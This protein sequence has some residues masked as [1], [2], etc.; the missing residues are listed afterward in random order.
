MDSI[1]NFLEAVV[2]LIFV[3][4]ALGFCI[5]SHELGHFLAAKWRGLHIDAFSLGFKPFWRKKINGVEYRLGWL[6]FG[7]YVELPQVDASD[8]VPKAADGTELPR[9]KPLDRIITAVAGPLFNILSGLLLGCIIWAVGMPQDSPRMHELSVLTVEK[10]SPE[11]AAGLR[12]GDKILTLN[13]K[14]FFLTWRN[15][16][17]ELMLATGE[18][19]LGVLRDGKPLT[20]RYRVV[21]NPDAP[22]SLGNEK[23]GWP[24]FTV[25]IPLELYPRSG[26]IAEQAGVRDGDLLVAVDG[27]PMQNYLE[28]QEALNRSQGKDLKIALQRD[29]KPVEVTMAAT[30]MPQYARYLIGIQMEQKNESSNILVSQVF[31]G[32]PAEAAGIRAGDTLLEA[33]E[34]PLTAMAKFQE[35]L[36]ERKSEPFRLTYL[37]DGVKSSVEIAAREEIPYSI[38][39]DLSALD[40]PTPFQQFYDTIELSYKS[41]RG[42][43]VGLANKIGLTRETS[44]LKPSHMSGPLGIGM[45][46]FNSVHHSSLWTGIYFMV[47]ISFALAIFNLLP[48]PVLDGG[49]ILFG[50]IELVFRRPVPVVVLKSLSTVFVTLLIG[51]MLYV[52]FYDG[53]RLLYQL[54]LLKPA[55]EN[56]HVDTPKK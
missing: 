17:K 15:F 10:K 28:F 42:M 9:A 18:V 27:K 43:L 7:G 29:G 39:V 20:I 34:T 1:L 50:L 52:T 55:A 11:Y 13:G 35:Y 38:G 32:S 19:E 30:P 41:L 25:M 31:P 14:S 22:G 56:T 53:K 37:R 51:M 36:A 47:M 54:N 44:T 23:I 49:H 26:S 16:A 21:D 46:L 24:F 2:S 40:H 4:V 8:A 33:G 48:L 5:F 6:P 45:V 3:F 12:P